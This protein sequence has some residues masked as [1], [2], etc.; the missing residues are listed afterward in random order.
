MPIYEYECP[1]CGEF[2]HM[3]AVSAKPLRKCPTCGRRVR[4]LISSS[5]FRLLGGGWYAD[6][7]SSRKPS[8]NGSKGNGEAP[9]GEGEGSAERGAASDS[10]SD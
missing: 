5:S 10:S 7:Y 6:G 3:Q 4:K 9:K 1:Q 8:G 2:E